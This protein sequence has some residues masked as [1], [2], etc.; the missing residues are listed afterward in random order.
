MP[1][2]AGG[3]EWEL[4]PHRLLPTAAVASVDLYNCTIV[5][6][7]RFPFIKILQCM[8]LYVL[9]GSLV[10]FGEVKIG[11]TSMN[12]VKKVLCFSMDLVPQRKHCVLA[13]LTLETNNSCTYNHF[14]CLYFSKS[15]C[16]SS[17]SS[18]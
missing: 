6:E 16:S 1:F 8:Y 4:V 14:Y 3:Y 7:I 9:K 17:C 12:C 10:Q 11:K 2:E 15:I 18:S 5:V 13:E